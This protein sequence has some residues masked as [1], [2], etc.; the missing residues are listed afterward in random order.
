MEL[1][2]GGSVGM[3]DGGV[4]AT[5]ILL[6]HGVFWRVECLSLSQNAITKKGALALTR[7]LM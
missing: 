6:S 5:A 4:D 1:D 2:L 3:T 7:A